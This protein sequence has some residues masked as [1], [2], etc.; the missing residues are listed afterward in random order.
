MDLSSLERDVRALE[1][2][3]D[4]IQTWVSLSTLLVV[5]GVVL[6]YWQ[7]FYEFLDEVRNGP[8]FPWRRLAGVVGGFLVTVGVA[9]GLWFQSRSW[10]AGM[11]I[12]ERSHQIQGLLNR[13]AGTARMEAGSARERAAASEKKA[14][15]L[16]KLALDEQVA[17]V[18][19]EAKVQPRALETNQLSQL[20][21]MW[22]GF[23][24]SNRTTI[25]V[26]SCALDVEAKLLAGQML[27]TLAGAGF[28][29]VDQRAT[30]SPTADADSGVV[31]AGA[32]GQEKLVQATVNALNRSH[33]AAAGGPPLPSGAGVRILVGIKPLPF[34]RA[35]SS[36]QLQP[37]VDEKSG[38]PL[39]LN[40]HSAPKPA[41]SDV[42]PPLW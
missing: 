17:L 30:Y 35:S 28:K 37:V 20:R 6:A 8:A 41:A 4:A 39:S 19:L 5:V 3:L 23:A 34:T 10:I 7:S 32:P 18:E 36:A 22:S 15:W 2:S 16:N 42:Y 13:E 29:V 25:V 1:H 31:I 27:D 9:A 38:E 26:Q 12:N 24:R 21:D 11:L 40:L 33:I 14:A